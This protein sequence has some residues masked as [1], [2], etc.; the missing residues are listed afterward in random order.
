[1]N[2]QPRCVTSV[3]SRPCLDCLAG[4]HSANHNNICKSGNVMALSPAEAHIQRTIDLLQQE[5]DTDLAQTSLLSSKCSPKLLEARG[6]AI[7][8]LQVTNISVGLGGKTIVELERWMK[9]PLPSHSFR[10]GDICEI[11]GNDAGVNQPTSSKGKGKANDKSQDS[12]EAAKFQATVY[13]VHEEKL[14]VAMDS[15]DKDDQDPILPE[16][17]RW[18]ARLRQVVSLEL[19]AYVVL[20]H[21]CLSL[22]PKI[23]KYCHIR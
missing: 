5:R 17:C 3:K 10:N 12:P 13:R 6:L 1:M 4:Q 19:V 18:C 21:L 22:Q 20:L 7:L 2:W 23:G 11:L 16:K 9:G 14:V 15:K 8:N